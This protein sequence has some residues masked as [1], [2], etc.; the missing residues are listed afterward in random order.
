MSYPTYRC[1][2]NISPSLLDWWSWHNNLPKKS[3][4]TERAPIQRPP[5]AAAVGIYLFSSWIIEPSLCPLMIICWSFSCLATCKD[6]SRSDNYWKVMS[7]VSY[8]ALFSNSHKLRQWQHILDFKSIS[9]DSC[10]MSR[11]G[12]VVDISYWLSTALGLWSI[13]L[14]MAEAGL[15]LI[16]HYCHDSS[17]NLACDNEQTE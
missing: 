16:S 2:T 17:K 9:G 13:A 15:A 14:Q 11:S 5:K 12:N 6:R 7:S 4:M 3:A 1:M 8:N 10:P